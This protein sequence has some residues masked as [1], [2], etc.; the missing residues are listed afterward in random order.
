VITNAPLWLVTLSRFQGFQIHTPYFP[1]EKHVEEF[2]SILDSF[3]LA[4][5]GDFSPFRI[6][7]SEMGAPVPVVAGLEPIM[8]DYKY[9]DP[10][11]FRARVSGVVQYLIVV[12]SI[13]SGKVPTSGAKGP[14]EPNEIKAQ[15]S[16][17][18]I[19]IENMHGSQLIS[20]SPHASI[21]ISQSFNPKDQKFRDLISSIK[22]NAPR[23][24]LEK[25]SL[26]QINADIVTIEAQIESPAP[27]YTVIGESAY[28]IRG[29][30]ESVAGNVMT[31]ALLL[32]L[33]QFF[34]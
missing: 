27:K 24:G 2:H 14:S 5:K 6:K 26:N 23:L 17:L 4:S 34:S 20:G 29:I 9:C 7:D 25:D 8:K 10:T 32:G 15:P 3:Q 18:G 21:K 33:G 19:Y 31:Q 1:H 28:S 12:S 22:E 13:H 30:L 11:I 16:Q